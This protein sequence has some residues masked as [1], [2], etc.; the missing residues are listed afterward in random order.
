VRAID[1]HEFMSVDGVI[2]APTWTFDYGWDPSMG[3]AI[4]AVTERSRTLHLATCRSPPPSR[5]N[6][7]VYLATNHGRE[8]GVRSPTL[9]AV[10]RLF[11]L[12][13]AAPES[14]RPSLRLPDLTGFEAE[15][16]AVSAQRCRISALRASLGAIRIIAGLADPG[17]SRRRRRDAIRR[18]SSSATARAPAPSSTSTRMLSSIPLA[19]GGSR[20]RA[21]SVGQTDHGRLGHMNVS[22]Q[23]RTAGTST[24]AE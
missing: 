5:E 23:A 8:H 18:P 24:R 3:A 1:V 2:D 22:I 17:A 13:G 19:D 4:G 16:P 6:G 15:A 11:G 7:V 10:C 21:P 20:F 14:N 9:G 12:D